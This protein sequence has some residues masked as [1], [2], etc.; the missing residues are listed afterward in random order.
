MIYY[1]VKEIASLWGMSAQSIRKY[2]KDGKIPSAVLK[3]D[4]WKIPES[5]EK[6]GEPAEEKAGYSKLAKKIIYQKK[7]KYHHGIYEYLQITAAYRSNRLASNRLTI[8]QVENMYRTKRA[9]ACFEPTK[10]DD[11]IEVANHFDAMNFVIDTILTPLSVEYIKELHVLL[12]QSTFAQRSRAVSPGNYRR[13]PAKMNGQE[14]TEPGMINRELTALITGY[15][16]KKADLRKIVDFHARFE[17]IHPFE[18]YN[19]RVGRLIM[20][21]E[22]L[23]Y[24][25]DPFIIDD[26]KRSEYNMGIAMWDKNKFLLMDAVTVSQER[27]QEKME[28][29][30]LMQYGRED[31]D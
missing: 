26:K 9:T 23:R 6:P 21:K 13:K 22:C 4:G 15:E 11:I 3:S 27:F 2:C 10:V 28:L 30:R 8:R 14:L 7:K 1:T 17:H 18:D 24:D 5:A 31:G 19:G 16:K 29:C 25:V 20:I 12:S